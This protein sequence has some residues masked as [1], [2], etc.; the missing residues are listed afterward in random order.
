MHPFPRR[1]RCITLR[2]A[3]GDAQELH[4]VLKNH[5]CGVCIGYCKFVLA[6]LDG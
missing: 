6:V 2:H 3:L 4:I 1:T 5:L